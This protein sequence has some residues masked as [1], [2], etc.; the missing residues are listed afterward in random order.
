MPDLL[1]AALLAAAVG[2]VALALVEASD[3]GLASFRILGLL[4]ASFW[5]WTIIVN[6]TLLFRR[7][8]S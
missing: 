3:W 4:A 1:G 6:K 8:R 7:F 2:L 5:S